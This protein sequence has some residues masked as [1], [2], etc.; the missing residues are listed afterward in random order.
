MTPKEYSNY[1]KK[2]DE[3]RKKLKKAQPRPQL[4]YF[5]IKDLYDMS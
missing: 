5:T 2:I 4:K 1:I 3:Q